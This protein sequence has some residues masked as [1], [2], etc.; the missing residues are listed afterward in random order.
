MKRE[1]WFAA[2]LLI[3]TLLSARPPAG[4]ADPCP[5]AVAEVDTAEADKTDS[6][7]LRCGEAA[8]ESFLA[9]DTLI[10]SVAVWRIAGQTPYGGSLK[11]WITEVDSTGTPQVDRKVLDGPVITVR[12]VTA[13][14]RSRWS[15]RLTRPSPCRT[16]A[17]STSP[18]R[19]G[20]VG[21]GVCCWP[22]MMST[23]KGMP[24]DRGLPVL[25]QVAA[26]CGDPQIRS[27]PTISYSPSSSARQPTR[28]FGIRVGGV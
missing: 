4:L 6:M 12:S 15:G 26:I 8:G 3:G 19:T 9:A 20:A 10:H 17:D 25:T 2:V 5:S 27:S 14:I 24:H 1:N 18:P 28:Q 13:S 7:G 23:W 21:T 22:P 11:L 16:A